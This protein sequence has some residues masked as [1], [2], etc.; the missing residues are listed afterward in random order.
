MGSPGVGREDSSDSAGAGLARVSQAVSRAAL[1]QHH[2]AQ[3]RGPGIGNRWGPARDTG[4]EGG[5]GPSP[6]WAMGNHYPNVTDRGRPAGAGA[7]A[8]GTRAPRAARAT[9]KTERAASPEEKV[10]VAA[11]EVQPT[12]RKTLLSSETLRRLTGWSRRLDCS[13]DLRPTTWSRRPGT[14]GLGVHDRP[15]ADRGLQPAPSG[16]AWRGLGAWCGAW[17]GAGS[18]GSA[19]E[20]LG[21]SRSPLA[22]RHYPC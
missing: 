22:L 2:T 21:A 20:F 12:E 19:D 18:G 8:S 7:P 14:L 3:G 1:G 6:Q 15:S 4:S 10:K 13:W 9:R 11:P 16:G 17:P 5:P